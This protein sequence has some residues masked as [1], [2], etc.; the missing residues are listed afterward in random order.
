MSTSSTSDFRIREVSVCSED[1]IRHRGLFYDGGSSCTILHVHGKCGDFFQNQF[2]SRIGRVLTTAGYNL[3]AL[4]NRGSG[5]ISEA[6]RDENLIYVGGAVELFAD[7]VLDIGGALSYLQARGHEVILQGHSHGCE[8]VMWYSA[9]RGM[10]GIRGIVL[11][12]PANSRLIQEL[13]R[14]PESIA[15]QVERLQASHGDDDNLSL[16]PPDEYGVSTSE[17]AY[18]IPT[19]RFSLLHWLQ[20]PA[21]SVFSPTQSDWSAVLRSPTFAYLGARDD[22]QLEGLGSM[23]ECLQACAPDIELFV[24]EHGDHQM[25]GIETSVGTAILDWL[26]LNEFGDQRGS[27]HSIRDHARL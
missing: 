18:S 4:N 11:L 25:K 22:L 7:S 1:G 12:S 2:I 6:Y 23:L 26:R 5:C 21:L 8:K 10:D 16:L 19:T 3:L 17:K 20:N 9:E 15:G 24:H 14:T 13:W 27:P